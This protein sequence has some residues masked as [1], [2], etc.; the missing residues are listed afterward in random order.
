MPFYRALVRPGILAETQRERFA[1]DVVDVHC[2]VTGAP[3]S[4]VHVLFSEDGAGELPEANVAAVHGTIRGGRTDAQKTEI[5]TRLSH[6]L[7]E[8][9]GVDPSQVKATTSDVEASYTME[10]GVVL[11]EPGSP[12]EA[13]WVTPG[14]SS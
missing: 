6:L 9:A 8:R 7:A 10:G 14:V 4:F 11:P 3:P 12:E 13:A 2:D 1:R 5:T